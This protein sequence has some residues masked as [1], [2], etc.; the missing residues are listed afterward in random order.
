MFQTT[1]SCSVQSGQWIASINESLNTYAASARRARPK[2]GP[3]I[4]LLNR[5]ISSAGVSF[6]QTFT[7][8]NRESG[9]FSLTDIETNFLLLAQPKLILHAAYHTDRSPTCALVEYPRGGGLTPLKTNAINGFRDFT[10]CS[11]FGAD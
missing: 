1:N 6:H 5:R 11:V 3:L 4:P 9:I 8:I 2:T 7:W 10:L